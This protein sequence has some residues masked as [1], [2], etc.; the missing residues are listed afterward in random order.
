[1]ISNRRIIAE[2]FDIKKVDIL[3]EKFGGKAKNWTKY[4]TVDP[5]S[6]A[7]IHWYEHPGIGKVGAKWDGFPDP[8]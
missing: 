6:G 2:G 5:A 7:E 3:V 4:A 8:F 1:M